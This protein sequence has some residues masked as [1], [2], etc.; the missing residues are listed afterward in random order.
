MDAIE[1]AMDGVTDENYLASSMV[2]KAGVL[3]VNFEL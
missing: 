2:D 3:N 1:T